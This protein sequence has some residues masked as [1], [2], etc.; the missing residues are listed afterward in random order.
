MGGAPNVGA[1]MN[2][3]TGAGCTV[4][5]EVGEDTVT[6]GSTAGQEKE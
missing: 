6:A 4:G 3:G 1:G 5:N 2:K